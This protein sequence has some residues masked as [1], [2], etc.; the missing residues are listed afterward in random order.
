MENLITVVCLVDKVIMN[1][2]LDD[3]IHLKVSTNDISFWFCSVLC[4]LL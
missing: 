1:V 3:V 4:C 2:L